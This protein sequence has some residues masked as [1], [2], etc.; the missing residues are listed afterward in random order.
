M[1]KLTVIALP[2]FRIQVH[3]DKLAS[4]YK[5]KGKKQHDKQPV[6]KQTQIN[7]NN[8]TDHY[9][10]TVVLFIASYFVIISTYS[11][12]HLTFRFVSTSRKERANSS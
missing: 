4:K 2:C 12:I 9:N 3:F 7:D 1:L 6:D 8:V 5:Q 11:L 10:L